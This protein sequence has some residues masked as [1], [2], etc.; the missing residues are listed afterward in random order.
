VVGSISSVTDV[1]WF[2]FATQPDGARHSYTF[3]T[4]GL[5]GNCEIYSSMTCGEAPIAIGTKQS[6]SNNCT[7]NLTSSYVSRTYYVRLWESDWRADSSYKV[8]YGVTT[9]RPDGGGD[10]P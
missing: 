10:Y 2:S 7:V 1:D 4:S 5:N 8:A 3:G 6:G 9:V